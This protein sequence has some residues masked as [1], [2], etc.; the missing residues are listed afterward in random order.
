MA[1][2]NA[3][4]AVTASPSAIENCLMVVCGKAPPAATTF[5]RQPRSPAMRPAA[6]SA[7]L[8]PPAA[9][10]PGNCATDIAEVAFCFYWSSK[11]N[12]RRI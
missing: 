8:V 5:G 10:V 3:V 6:G 4:A 2:L 7:S 12:K 11:I 1:I 9:A